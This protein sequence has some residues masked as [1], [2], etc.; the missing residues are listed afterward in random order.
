MNFTLPPH[1]KFSKEKEKILLSLRSERA[2]LCPEAAPEP[3]ASDPALQ[4]E[5]GSGDPPPHPTAFGRRGGSLDPPVAP[6]IWGDS[7]APCGPREA[8]ERTAGAWCEVAGDPSQLA[9]PD[10]CVRGLVRPRAHPPPHFFSL[11]PPCSAWL[12]SSGVPPLVPSTVSKQLF[13]H[14]RAAAAG[15][16]RLARAQLPAAVP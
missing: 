16:A 2:E 6:K 12:P 8:L 7:T 11:L 15:C 9:R 3:S 10:S 4:R 1:L 14:M 13:Q 5:R